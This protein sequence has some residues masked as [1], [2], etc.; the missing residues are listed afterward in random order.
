MYHTP[1]FFTNKKIITDHTFV[2]TCMY[3]YMYI[4]KLCFPAKSAKT[5][6]YH[7]YNYCRYEV[8]VNGVVTRLS[9]PKPNNIFYYPNA[10]AVNNVSICNDDY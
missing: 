5:I 4:P 1:A 7:Y 8:Q 6:F 9:L 3:M 10:T 2:S